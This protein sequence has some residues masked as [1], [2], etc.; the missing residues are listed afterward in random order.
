M[1]RPEP[2][3]HI[4]P[5]CVAQ[6]TCSNQGH[7]PQ[8]YNRAAFEKAL[9]KSSVADKAGALKAYREA[10]DGKSNADARDIAKDILG[11]PIYWDWDRAYS[12]LCL[13]NMLL[14]EFHSA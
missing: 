10:A 12:H 9:E 14:N 8:W 5:R 6:V 7:T 3:L 13:R 11:E 2:A 4:R 1:A